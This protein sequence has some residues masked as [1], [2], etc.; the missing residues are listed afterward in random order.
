MGKR[1]EV[2]YTKAT[3]EGTMAEDDTITFEYPGALDEFG[4]IDGRELAK[5]LIDDAFSLLVPYAK[6]CRE[7]SISLFTGFANPVI[8]GAVQE[9]ILKGRVCSYKGDTK[10]ENTKFFEAHRDK[11]QAVTDAALDAGVEARAGAVREH[12]H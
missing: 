6:G 1:G 8:L 12:H 2:C 10:E 11:T 4:V 7:C 3:E 9:E 5:R